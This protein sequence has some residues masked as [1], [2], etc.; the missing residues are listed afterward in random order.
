MV[1]L[2]SP[3]FDQSPRLPERIDLGL[4][5]IEFRARRN[6]AN[7]AGIEVIPAA[8]GAIGSAPAARPR[9]PLCA[10]GPGTH[11]KPRPRGAHEPFLDNGLRLSEGTWYW[12]GASGELDA[13]RGQNEPGTGS[14]AY[15]LHQGLPP[16]EA[17]PC[18][19]PPA[20]CR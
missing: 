5:E 8:A 14:T 11:R 6:G 7:V 2:P 9:D 19:T 1:V 16:E 18:E 13:G 20:S 3:R 10:H 17:L 12:F 4:L 15:R